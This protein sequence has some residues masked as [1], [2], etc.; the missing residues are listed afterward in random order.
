[1]RLAWLF[2]IATIATRVHADTVLATTPREQALRLYQQ[3]KKMFSDEDWIA[4]AVTFGQAQAILARVDRD[5][6][7][8]VIDNEA[9]RYRNA[10]LS[11]KATSYSR[12][13][14]YVDA[15]N[16][17]VELR[18]QF[19]TELSKTEREEVDDAIARMAERIGTVKLSGLPSE[20]DVEVRFDGRL[21]RRD[22]H[23]PL[24][25]SEGDHSIDVKATGFKPYVAELTVVRQ[26]ELALAVT[27]EPLK[28]PAKLRVEAS[29][30][31]RV[32]IDGSER[33]DAPIEIS[34]PPGK[35]HIVVAAESYVT[36][37]S[38]VELKPD[39]R[40]IVRVGMVRA[41]AS[42]G[43]RL[44]PAYLASFPLRTDTPFGSYGGGIGVTVF[45]DTFR[46]RN[47]R[48]GLSM[49]HYPRRLNS[50]A[51]G[52]IG[53]WCPDRFAG[54]IAW[55]PVAASA[56]YVFGDHDG[57][58]TTGEGRLRGLTAVEARYRSGFARASAGLTVENYARDFPTTTGTSYTVLIMWASVL[59]L[60][61]GVDL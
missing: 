13:G 33:G 56:S 26:Q 19:G 41:R 59:E 16:A 27:L 60:S 52:A 17:F 30:A 11:N 42:I 47:V 37:T 24:R 23:A 3:A 5:P 1:M 18:D 50:E 10:A 22:L 43:L 40:A 25:M 15:F 57:V 38:D 2:V 55:C 34:L 58:F 44:A 35:H 31:A 51:I 54:A 7:G 14:L 48:F 45:H 39:E 4:A 8:K 49:E 21:E 20:G 9:H 6:S 46:V 29:A 28:T 61:L 53:T 36:Q 12:G 32:E